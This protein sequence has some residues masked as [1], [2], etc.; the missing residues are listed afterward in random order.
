M[1][2]QYL[3]SAALIGFGLLFSAAQPARASSTPNV[4]DFVGF[5][6]FSS[7][8]PGSC[9]LANAG[10]GSQGGIGTSAIGISNFGSFTTSQSADGWDNRATADTI[11]NSSAIASASLHDGTL[12]GSARATP[13]LAALGGSAA[14]SVA[15][16]IADTITFNNSSGSTVYLPWGFTLDG[17]ISGGAEDGSSY[18]RILSLTNILN[19]AS[20]DYFNPITLVGP[21]YATSGGLQVGVNTD[22]PYFLDIGAGGNAAD[23]DLVVSYDPLSGLVA[24]H[25]LTMLAIPNGISSLGFDFELKFQCYGSDANCDFGHTG[26]VAFGALPNGLSYTSASGVFLQGFGGAGGVPEPASWA[27]MLAGFGLTGAAMR[28]RAQVRVTYA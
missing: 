28:R 11:Y 8:A 15:M 21:N 3:A 9:A 23:Y 12:R 27:M 14:S 19:F 10:G 4:C 26:R 22:H 25:G 18:R 1:K 16:A 13:F 20:L 24:A 6:F 17:R 7:Y 5:A 2:R